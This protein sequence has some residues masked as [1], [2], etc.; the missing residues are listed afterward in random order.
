MFNYFKDLEPMKYYEAGKNLS[1]NLQKKKQDMLD[2]KDNAFVASK[3]N[4]GEW[5]MFV[6][7]GDQIIIKSRSVSKKTGGYGDKTQHLPHIVEEM[8]Q[9]D[10]DCVAIGEL[11]FDDPD[12]V[13]TD[14]GTVLRCLPEKAIARQNAFGAL[15]VRLFDILYYGDK[16]LM[17][18]PYIDRIKYIDKVVGKNI[19]STEFYFDDFEEHALELMSQG[20]EGLVIQRKEYIYEPGKKSAWKTLKVKQR[21]EDMELKV[22]KSIPANKEYAGKAPEDWPYW[23]NGEPIS[24]PYKN[25]WHMG[26]TV[27]FNGKMVD[28]SSGLRDVDREWLPTAEAQEK[29][30]N[31]E[32]Y[33]VV[34]AM[35]VT[36]D[37]S[38]RHP[39]VIRFRD[40]M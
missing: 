1:A 33:A 20:W 9:W 28:V 36:E 5:G 14:V 2:N 22:V 3:K 25:G 18:E 34:G 37:G 13:S 35:L 27:D 21:T 7:F 24:K 12:S 38:L 8:K 40:D 23:E 39:R 17:N 26:V 32:L 19:L 16:N 29:I 11:C 4:D 31:G 15:G 10:F 30:K 6:K